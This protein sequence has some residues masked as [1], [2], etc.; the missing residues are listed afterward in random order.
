MSKSQTQTEPY[1]YVREFRRTRMGGVTY[2]IAYCPTCRC[3]L[4][5]TRFRR[6]RRGTHGEDHWVHEHPL[7]FMELSSSNAGNRALWADQNIPETLYRLAERA[8]IHE[9]R[10]PNEVEELL[11]ESLKGESQ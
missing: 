7:A 6:S 10:A 3:I 4:P 8:W 9:G 11:V 1:W 5:P 2:Y